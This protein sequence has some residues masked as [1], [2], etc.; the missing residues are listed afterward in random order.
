MGCV[1]Y[2]NILPFKTINIKYLQESIALEIRIRRKC[3]KFSCFYRY[4]SQTNDKFESFLKNFELTSDKIH[5]ETPLMI[6]VLH[7]FNAKYI[8]WCKNDT[9]SHEG[10]MIDVVTSSYGLCQLLQEPTHT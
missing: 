10:S 3:C 2:K 1:Y 7:D 5:K 9:T 4:P 6:P 8:K